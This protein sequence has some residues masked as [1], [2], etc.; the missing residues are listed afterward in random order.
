VSSWR[1]NQ[2]KKVVQKNAFFHT[3]S[4]TFSNIFKRFT[5]LFEYFQTF[6]SVFFLPI[7][8]KPHNLTSQPPFLPQLPAYLIDFYCLNPQIPAF[9]PLFYCPNPQKANL[10]VKKFSI[11]L[12]LGNFCR[13]Y[14]KTLDFVL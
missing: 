12:I 10:R 6:L 4:H 1:K 13:K 9:F 3:F 14:N 2:C 5:L 7:L 11:L 8:P